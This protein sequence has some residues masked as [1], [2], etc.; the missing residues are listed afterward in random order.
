MGIDFFD[1]A[2]Q[3]TYA[4]RMASRDWRESMTRLGPGRL[5]C[6]PRVQNCL[7]YVERPLLR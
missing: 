5:V 4:D 7:P 1:P 6:R 3:G 2:N